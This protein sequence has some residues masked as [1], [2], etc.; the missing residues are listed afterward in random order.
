MPPNFFGALI[1]KDRPYFALCILSK[2]YRRRRKK[3]RREK[4][5][6]ERIEG[7]KEKWGDVS[8]GSGKEKEEKKECLREVAFVK[9]SLV[10]FAMNWGNTGRF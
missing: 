10:V 7:K 6:E 4:A 5:N 9:L 3:N 1:L 8:G 2:K